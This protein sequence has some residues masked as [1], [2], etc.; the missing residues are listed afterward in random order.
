MRR[1]PTM[2]K[3]APHLILTMKVSK[4]RIRNT[5]FIVII[6]LM[7]IPQTRTPI[8]VFINK[9]L[10][11]ISPSIVKE[12]KRE[13]ILDYNWQLQD[14]EGQTMNFSDSKNKVVL[15]NFWATW[16]PPCIAEMPSLDKLYE[17]YKDRV[18]FYFVS[19][20]KIEVIQGFMDK[21]KYGFKVQNP[22]TKYP[23]VFDISSIPRTYLIDK[24]GSIVMDKAGAANW[25]SDK[26]RTQIDTLL[27]E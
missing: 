23:E 4:S 9:G 16:C 26:V 15:I 22:T 11:L 18:D 3:T 6:A 21:N 1:N 14:G 5:V 12:S 27:N 24:S 19:N 17:D 13:R 10:A 8:Q 2:K 7:I 20:E 25:N